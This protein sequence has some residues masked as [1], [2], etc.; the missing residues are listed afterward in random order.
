MALTSLF[1]GLYGC[2]KEKAPSSTVG[3]LTKEDAELRD[4]FRDL[5]G[6]E[7]FVDASVFLDNTVIYKPNGSTFPGGLGY[8]G[9][10]NGLKTGFFGDEKQGE[11]FAVPKSLRYV[12]YPSGATV[13]GDIHT[14]VANRQPPWLGEPAIDV[15][16][17]V[18]SR[19][20]IET[21]DRVRKYKG[22][23]TLK[24]RLTPETLLIGWEIKNGRSYPFKMDKNG[25][26]YVTDEDVMK[27]GDFCER[28]V[29][30]TPVNGELKLV[31]IKGWYID[32]KSG[33]K[34]ATDF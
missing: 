5:K 21:L 28:Q 8:Y 33:Q 31:E 13:N 6:G 34:I 22:V 20:P 11:T 29:R 9:P 32:P 24:L 4:K 15:T 17:P 10:G 26:K 23:L 3:T 2:T 7:L 1:F 19:I 16:V 18:A 14:A 25:L 30:D 12:R 27:G